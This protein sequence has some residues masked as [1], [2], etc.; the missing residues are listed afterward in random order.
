[1][2][3]CP[4]GLS[5]GFGL[6]GSLANSVCVSRS[7]F[8]RDSSGLGVYVSG[9]G[10][11]MRTVGN[12]SIVCTA[13]HNLYHSDLGRPARWIA[14]YFGRRDE[15]AAASRSVKR[16]LFPDEFRDD[17]APVQW[18]FGIAFI[19]ALGSDRFHPI[20][21]RGSTAVGD[22]EKLLVGYPNEGA[23]KGRFQPYH[24]QVAVFPSGPSNYGYRPQTTYVG[25]SGG[26]LLARPDGTLLSYGVHVRGDSG[27]PNGHRAVR[28]TPPV[29]AR[30]LDW[31]D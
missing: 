16:A 4:S 1:M 7:Y 27:D 3:S 24:A 5:I 8:G 13:A 23:C 18:D 12:V 9:T 31:L 15:S 20:A 11:L 25:M 17:Y 26:P 19:D 21:P 30:I 22:T 6:S 10:W 28:F 14:L 2:A 29:L